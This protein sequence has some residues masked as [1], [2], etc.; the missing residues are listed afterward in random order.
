MPSIKQFDLRRNA[1]V[2]TGG[3]GLAFDPALY[4]NV[5]GVVTLT[6]PDIVI[7]VPKAAG[8]VA[9]ITALGTGNQ[10]VIHTEGGNVACDILSIAFHTV[11]RVVSG[12]NKQLYL[13]A[14]T[15]IAAAGTSI[16][17]LLKQGGVLVAPDIAIPVPKVVP[18]VLTKRP[19]V[20]TVMATGAIVVSS[21]EVG[22]VNNDVA[23]IRMHTI[24][25][26][27]AQVFGGNQ[28]RNRYFT[29]LDTAD[30]AAGSIFVDAADTTRRYE[31][32][33]TKVSADGS[34]QLKC[35]QTAGTASGATGNLN[36]YE[37]TGDAVIAWTALLFEKYADLQSNVAVANGAGLTFNPGLVVNGV[38]VMPDIVI[39]VPKAVDIVPFVPTD[40]AGAVGSVNVQING[41]AP[42]NCDILSL[43]VATNFG[44]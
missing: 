22:A 21:G 35:R 12:D 37:G 24:Q 7:P 34:L 16:D 27:L 2:P 20:A 40:L 19:F 33:R 28:D 30:A 13:A 18:S 1:V 23:M 25:R 26:L 17:P 42:A 44:Q 43:K 14:A 39:P 31:V 11:Q 29:V 8:S 5:G 15:S 32:M 38:A 36:L 4:T 41:G 3:A 6:A 9:A 10:S